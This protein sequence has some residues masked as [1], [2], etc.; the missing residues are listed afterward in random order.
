MPQN[1]AV[2]YGKKVLIYCVIATTS[3]K[4][5][6]CRGI[7]LTATFALKWDLPFVSPKLTLKGVATL[8]RGFF[9]VYH[10]VA[11]GS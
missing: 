9:C 11:L 2:I 6:C 4:Y 5:S 3:I 1:F 10:P 7:I 8:F